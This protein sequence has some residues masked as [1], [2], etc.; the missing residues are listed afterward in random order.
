MIAFLSD[1]RFASLAF[2]FLKE[3]IFSN[4]TLTGKHSLMFV[5]SL[6]F[7][8]RLLVK[9]CILIEL[10]ANINVK[11]LKTLFIYFFIFFFYLLYLF[12]IYLIFIIF[13]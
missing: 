2:L 13:F 10:A 9:S 4:K 3:N 12:L 8:S 11:R 7:N 5:S 1:L 6:S